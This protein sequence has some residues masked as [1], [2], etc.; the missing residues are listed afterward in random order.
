MDASN[1]RAQPAP[2]LW[3]LALS[4]ARVAVGFRRRDEADSDP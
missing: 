2:S 4:A 3:A 1:F